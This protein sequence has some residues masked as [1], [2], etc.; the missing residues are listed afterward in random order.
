MFRN[1]RSQFSD[2]PLKLGPVLR[3]NGVCA[4]GE[5]SSLSVG[6]H[7]LSLPESRGFADTGNPV[8]DGGRLCEI[9][10]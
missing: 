9:L 6:G 4:K 10:G 8:G 3:G 5:D 7:L 1:R 2:N